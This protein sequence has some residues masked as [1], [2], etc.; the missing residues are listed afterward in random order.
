MC[1][2]VGVPPPGRTPE[3]RQ[4]PDKIATA[5]ELSSGFALLHEVGGRILPRVTCLGQLDA[6]VEELSHPHR[7]ELLAGLV[8]EVGRNVGQVEVEA[9]TLGQGVDAVEIP[10]PPGCGSGSRWCGR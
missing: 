3:H 8:G 2:W 9:V 6:A 1:A 4:G 7:V 10:D 5:S